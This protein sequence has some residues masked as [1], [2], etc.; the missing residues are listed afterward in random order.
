MSAEQ[1]AAGWP[2]AI[3][4]MNQP[5]RRNTRPVITAALELNGGPFPFGPYNSRAEA[6]EDLIGNVPDWQGPIFTGENVEFVAC[7]PADVAHFFQ[8]L[9]VRARIEVGPAAELWLTAAN[10]NHRQ[11][12][13]DFVNAYIA[14]QPTLK[15]FFGQLKNIRRH[16]GPQ[17]DCEGQ[18]VTGLE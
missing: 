6:I 10:D 12:L 7:T 18:P 13:A 16:D 8:R 9:R 15:P 11:Q 1:Y 3:A 2:E 4:K 17:Y 14:G 5:E